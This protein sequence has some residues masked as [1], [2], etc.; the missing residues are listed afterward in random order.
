[1]YGGKL[2]VIELKSR[3]GKCNLPQRL[4]R[5]APLRAGA[6]W[7]VV[8][9]ARAAMCALRKSGVRFRTAFSDDGTIECWQQPKLPAW[10]VPKRDPHERRPRA[11]EWGARAGGGAC[12]ASG[13]ARRRRT[14]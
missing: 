5:E 6:R 4:V 2:I 3:S 7:W 9:S 8:R 11:P 14:G 13:G 10:E 1:L 12:R